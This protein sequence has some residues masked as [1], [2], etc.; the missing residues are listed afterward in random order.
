M[1]DDFGNL[2]HP[3]GTAAL[4]A[5][6]DAGDARMTRIEQD[7]AVN[8]T[9][10]RETADNTSELVDIF[11][12]FKGAMKVLEYVGKLAKPLGYIL[13]AGLAVAAVWVAV[14]TGGQSR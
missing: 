9:A 12:A 1:Q 13:K 2:V 8:T 6:L 7:L 3:P 10:T 5:R 11:K 14:K 4:T